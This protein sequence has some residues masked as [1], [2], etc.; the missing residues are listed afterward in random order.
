M[1]V[2][3]AL[4]GSIFALSKKEKF[5][6]FTYKKAK[7]LLIPLI[8]VWILWNF[9][10]K[11]FTGY[12]TNVSTSKIFI[13]LIFPASVH[14]WYL[15]CL[16]FVFILAFYIVKFS[17]K[18][19][20]FIVFI[21]WGV[22]IVVYMRL[23]QCHPLGDPLYYLGWFYLGYRIEDTIIV[24]LKKIHF[25]NDFAICSI[26][27]MDIVVFGINRIFTIKLLNPLCTYI[28]F[29]IMMF[30]V[31]NY[32]SRRINFKG[33]WLE[34]V[35]GYGMGIYLYAEPLNYLL[36]YLFYN[37]Y[38]IKYFGTNVGAA[39]IYFSRLLITPLVAIVITWILKKLNFKYLY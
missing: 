25:W 15:E 16:F 23:G 12:Y 9:P 3:I 13:Q 20:E 39:T 28:F 33:K 27:V 5:I 37:Y 24:A 35:S 31:L 8:V 36:L 38:G 22:G 1:P 2:F 34:K 21:L 7:R 11:Y 18:V 26:F 4:S 14:L 30:I 29:P 10:I 17:K 19:Q 32:L 6:I